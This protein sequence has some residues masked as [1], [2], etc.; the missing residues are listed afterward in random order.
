MKCFPLLVVLLFTVSC[1]S[2]SGSVTI[3]PTDD[4]VQEE[5]VEEGPDEEV[6]MAS[7]F[8][9]GVMRNL[10]A[11]EIVA[12]MK[13]GWNLG[14][15]LDVEGPVETFWG[16]PVTTRAMIDE[17]SNRG[18]TTLRVPV[19]WRFH[20]GLAPNYTVEKSWLDRVEEVVNYGRAN[21]MYVIIN[22]HHDDPWIIPTYDKGD[23][24]KDRLSKLW[25]QIANRFKNYSDYV[26]FETL[27]EPR[28]EG[29]PEEWTGGT[30]EGRDMVNQYHQVSLDAI[31][32]TGGNNSS[33]Q[34]MISTYAAST[35]PLA[36]DALVVPN[37]DA[38][39]IISLHS[40]F[41][42]PFTLEGTDSTWGTAEDR[43]ELE[44][45]MDRIKAKFTDNGKAVVL[46]EWASGNQNNLEDRLA[47][48]TYYAQLASER[49][50]ASIWWDNGNNL[51]SNDGLALFNRQTLS[52]PFG[53]IRT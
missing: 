52:W 5:P 10:S 13:T 48:A 28:Y 37:D 50:F 43:A 9:D 29:S 4:T 15:S 44:A 22:V 41:P 39:T 31:R 49:G 20:Q 33:R 46:G 2:D 42:F 7:E 3:I 12:E 34:I 8:D 40:Y 51:V 25:S 6:G 30:A 14:N 17:V 1:G 26:I 18:F 23:E 32:A 45:E 38:H 16:N 47:H 21:N 11:V 36:M 19:T 35:I 24:V 53:E 27:N